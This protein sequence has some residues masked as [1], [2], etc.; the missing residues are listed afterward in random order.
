MS[1][2]V[3]LM[4]S[5]FAAILAFAGLVWIVSAFDYF[6]HRWG[7][8]EPVIYRGEAETQIRSGFRPCPIC[9]P[10]TPPEPHCPRCHGEG[11]VPV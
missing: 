2:A 5:V 1:D 11:E 9:S 6:V 8:Y 3:Y 4:L 7:G 10:L